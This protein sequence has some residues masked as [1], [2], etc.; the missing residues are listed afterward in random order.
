MRL[1]WAW[2]VMAA[3]VI[4]GAVSF[5]V[6]HVE[7]PRYL[8]VQEAI[9]AGDPVDVKYHLT[10]GTELT[11]MDESGYTL[12]H[13]A[14]V[15]DRPEVAELLLSRGLDADRIEKGRTVRN[16]TALH[17][18]ARENAHEVA[19]L[20]LESGA[21]ANA[22]DTEGLTPLHLAARNDSVEVARVLLEHDAEVNARDNHGQTPL[23]MAVKWNKP[24]VGRVLV[25]YH[26]VK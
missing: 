16:Y 17:L 14:A 1:R 10:H 22:R 2:L 7:R 19:T 3:S 11:E 24:H 21:D 9:R 25:Q 13:L 6:F 12:L 20:L 18:A 26:G 23:G 15:Y 5:R 8:T 4:L